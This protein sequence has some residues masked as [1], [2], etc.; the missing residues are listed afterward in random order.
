MGLKKKKNN[1]NTCTV[2]KELVHIASPKIQRPQYSQYSQLRLPWWVLTLVEATASCT[3]SIMNSL[4]I[5][6][7]GSSLKR[8]LIRATLAASRLASALLKQHL[9]REGERSH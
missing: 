8:E 4:V 6:R 7:E 2:L 5:R 3:L 1:K 9:R